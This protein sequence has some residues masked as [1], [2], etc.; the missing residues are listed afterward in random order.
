MTIANSYLVL[1]RN[2]L[3]GTAGAIAGSSEMLRAEGVLYEST[4]QASEKYQ[5][6]SNTLMDAITLADE[7][8]VPRWLPRVVDGALLLIKA[9]CLASLGSDALS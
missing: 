9:L 4:A 8:S 6:C 2:S 5:L 1:D 3:T 7:L